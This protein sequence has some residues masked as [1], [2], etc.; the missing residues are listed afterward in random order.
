[1]RFGSEEIT[2]ASTISS[3]TNDHLPRRSHAIDRHAEASPNV[4]VSL[5]IGALH[6]QIATSGRSARTATSFS[7]LT[8]EENSR[9]LPFFFSRSLP[10]VEYVGM[11]GTPIA[12]ACSAS[13]SVKF[14]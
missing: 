13:A 8:G 12:P 7:S 2:L 14:E 4:R 6:V 10:S 9:R 5:R 3:A 11:N 1:M